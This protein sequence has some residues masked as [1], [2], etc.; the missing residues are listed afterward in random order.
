MLNFLFGY[1]SPDQSLRHAMMMDQ[2]RQ[3]GTD[4]QRA[5]LNKLSNLRKP[6]YKISEPTI[7][8]GEGGEDETELDWD[9]TTDLQCI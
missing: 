5:A 8:G 9:T 4:M 7:K 6:M 3:A 1:S 2:Y